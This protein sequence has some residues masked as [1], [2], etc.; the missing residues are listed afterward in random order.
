[1]KSNRVLILVIIL[2]VAGAAVVIQQF[3]SM[4]QVE[5]LEQEAFI[6]VK[7]MEVRQAQMKIQVAEKMK[8]EAI[9]AAR[10]ANTEIQ[11]ANQIAREEIRK[12]NEETKRMAAKLKAMEEA[13]RAAAQS[14]VTAPVVNGNPSE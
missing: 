5:R 2:V 1:M 6:R 12:A 8:L 7:T 11:M 14:A 3:T 10:K 4:Q 13:A 9:E